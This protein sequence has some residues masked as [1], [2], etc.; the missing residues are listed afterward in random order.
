MWFLIIY[1]SQVHHRSSCLHA[2]V[3][4]VIRHVIVFR[5]G[6]VAMIMTL[7]WLTS[8]VM[9]GNGVGDV[10]CCGSGGG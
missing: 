10:P 4:I 3:I 8:V 9:V 5:G 2:I 7:S 1:T 6:N